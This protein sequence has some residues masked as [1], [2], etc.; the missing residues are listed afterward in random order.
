MKEYRS[1]FSSVWEVIEQDP[2]KDLYEADS[3]IVGAFGTATGALI[4]SQ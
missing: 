3:L 2:R 4:S 1:R